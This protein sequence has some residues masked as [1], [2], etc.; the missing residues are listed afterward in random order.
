MSIRRQ[1]LAEHPLLPRWG[2]RQDYGR[3]ADLRS[4][5]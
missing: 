2:K 4:A 5:V 1:C 3:V